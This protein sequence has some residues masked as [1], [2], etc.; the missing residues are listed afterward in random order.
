MLEGSADG[1][2]LLG[3]GRVPAP[4]KEG[5]GHAG[6]VSANP[7]SLHQGWRGGTGRREPEWGLRQAAHPPC[8]T[9]QDSWRKAPPSIFK[10]QALSSHCCRTCYKKCYSFRGLLTDGQKGSVLK[11]RERHRDP[12][13]SQ[14]LEEQRWAAANVAS[15]SGTTELTY[16]REQSL[17]GAAGG[18]S[19]TLYDPAAHSHPIISPFPYWPVSPT[20]LG[21]SAGA[22][23]RKC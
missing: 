23:Q 7:W 2:W 20:Q 12:S 10:R 17:R 19:S 4:Q 8:P 18:S 22:L 21:L 13:D 16:P 15:G 9:P 3:P 14:G 6:D 5:A 11:Q 1:W